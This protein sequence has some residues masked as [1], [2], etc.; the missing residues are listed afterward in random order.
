MNLCFSTLPCPEL[1]CNGLAEACRK[2]GI[3]GVEIRL[4]P[5]GEIYAG[6][7]RA[8]ESHRKILNNAGVRVTDIGSGVCIK[9]QDAA[10]L[11]KLKDAIDIA[12]IMGASAVRVFLG[13]FLE[14]KNGPR[15]EII[16]GEIVNMLKSGCD[17][18]AEKNVRVWV[19]TH[20]EYSRG[21][22]LRR[23]ME[24]A[25]R[26]N[27]GIIWDIIHP[28][29]ENEGVYETYEY[30]G[31]Y[32]EH[33]HIKD[34]RPSP[35]E[36]AASWEYMPIG[37]GRAPLGDIINILKRADYKGYYSLEWENAW[38]EELKKYPTDINW[39]LSEFVKNMEKF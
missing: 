19:E 26:G 5:S 1:D 11:E 9:R 24:D 13:N 15:E 34:A 21:K 27:I 38:R 39:I 6:A 3:G 14:K 33:I 17:Y 23:L 22:V 16:H 12:D 30:I 10:T 25:A 18:A 4:S 7:G 29:E 36:N 28:L 8:S 37:Q 2:Y 32:I 35:D 31:K 20:N